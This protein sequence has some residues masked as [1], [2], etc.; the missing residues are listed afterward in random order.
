MNTISK[1][2]LR[3][4]GLAR[5]R[6]GSYFPE[7]AVK[8]LDPEVGLNLTV[9]ICRYSVSVCEGGWDDLQRA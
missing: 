6:V 7:V 1:I 8:Q 5:I 4:I 3:Q 9:K 2:L